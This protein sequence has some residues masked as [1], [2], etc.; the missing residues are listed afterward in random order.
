M[1]EVLRFYY[2]SPRDPIGMQGDFYTSADL[3]PIFGYLLA[4]QFSEWAA[5][6]DAFTLVELGAGISAG[7]ARQRPDANCARASASCDKRRTE[8]ADRRRVRNRRRRGLKHCADYFDLS[9]LAHETNRSRR[10]Y[11]TTSGPGSLCGQPAWGGG[12]DRIVKST[13]DLYDPVATA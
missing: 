5:D 13:L 7:L 4:K 1:E 6:F 12:C 11:R 10:R 3:D 2:A 9:C 8:L